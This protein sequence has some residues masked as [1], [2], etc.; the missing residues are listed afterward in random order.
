MTV[1][2]Q[3]PGLHDVPATSSAE[4]VLG[5]GSAGRSKYRYVYS[6]AIQKGLRDRDTLS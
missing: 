1:S 5:K 2:G 3:G 6:Q 4:E